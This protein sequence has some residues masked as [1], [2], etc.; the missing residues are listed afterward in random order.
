MSDNEQSGADGSGH[1]AIDRPRRLGRCSGSSRRDARGRRR[2]RCRPTRA[3]RCRR[4]GRGSTRS[5]GRGRAHSA[6]ARRRCSGAAPRAAAAGAAGALGVLRSFGAAASASDRQDRAEQG[7]GH[8]ML[9]HRAS[10][11]TQCTSRIGPCR[12]HANVSRSGQSSF[13]NRQVRQELHGSGSSSGT[14]LIAY[15]V[16]T[17]INL[18]DITRQ[19][20]LNGM[21]RERTGA[22]II[23]ECLVHEGVTHRVRLSRRRDP[24]GL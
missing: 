20:T 9:R 23:W 24:A 7:G 22:Q 11:R 21:P 8:H 14:L 19:G 18:T 12:S 13:G 17:T 16:R 2:R 1:I 3:R 5:R 10:P 6:A 15:V 4:P